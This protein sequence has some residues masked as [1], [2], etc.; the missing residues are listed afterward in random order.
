MCL[1]ARTLYF[2]THLF[3]SSLHAR[4]EDCKRRWPSPIER[5]NTGSRAL[6]AAR[7]PSDSEVLAFLEEQRKALRAERKRAGR[8]VL[9]RA[10][11]N[12]FGLSHK[13]AL[14]I[15][16]HVPRDHKG[17]RPKKTKPETTG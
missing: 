16:S 6:T 9:L 11:M 15:W 3:W 8:D 5:T 7:R 14:N 2:D 13:V 1:G 12:R 17:G 10:A 4:A